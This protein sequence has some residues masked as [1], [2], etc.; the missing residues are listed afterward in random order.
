MIHHPLNAQETIDGNF[1]S[2]QSSITDLRRQG[3]MAG[4]GDGR[5]KGEV[6]DQLAIGDPGP[7]NIRPC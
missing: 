3:Q 2:S 5:G 6:D 4:A 7:C 1:N